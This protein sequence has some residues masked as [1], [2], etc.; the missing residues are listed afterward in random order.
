M[1]YLQLE[2]NTPFPTSTKQLLAKRMGEIY[3]NIMMTDPRRITISIREVGEGA[4]WRCSEDEPKP[5]A[6]LMCDIREGRPPQLREELAK[7]LIGVCNE[8]LELPI[9]DLNVEFTQ[10]AGDEMYHQWIGHMSD[11]WSPEEGRNNSS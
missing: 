4:V 3:A 8:L 6:I 10:H 1:P 11:N 9:N 2:I 7:M 5:A